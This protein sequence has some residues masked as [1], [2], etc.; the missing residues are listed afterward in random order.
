[1]KL[2]A[3]ALLFSLGFVS[4]A[5]ALPSFSNHPELI[6]EV[7]ESQHFK[8]IY[9]RTQE[10]NSYEVVA[11]EVLR[12]AEDA[13]DFVT[14]DLQVE[15]SKKTPIVLIGY[16][17]E[18]N[19]LA[20]AIN[21]SM[22]VWIPGMTQV[23]TGSMD[24]LRRTV[25]HEFTHVATY[26]K[27]EGNFPLLSKLQNLAAIP[28]WFIEGIAQ[29]E[30]E[31]L[32]N[33]RE[34]FLRVNTLEDSLLPYDRL[35]VGFLGTNIRDSRLVYEQ[36]FG[37]VRYIAGKYGREGIPQILS[38]VRRGY[39]FDDAV[40][41][42]T[43]STPQEIYRAWYKDTVIRY[44]SQAKGK[45]DLN[46][47]GSRL[48]NTFGFNYHPV[49]SPDGRR[50]AFA[51]S[52]SNDFALNDLYVMDR[53][54]GNQRAI[55]RD[56]GFTHSWSPDGQ[57]IVYSKKGV[58]W[59]WGE[60]VS[61]LYVIGADGSGR[62]QLTF[63]LF[64]WDPAF[65][66]DGERIA[67]VRTFGGRSEIYKMNA[68]GTGIERITH[69]V[70]FAENFGP[71]WSPDGKWIAFSTFQGG[72]RDIAVIDT[73]G[74]NFRKL[75]DDVADDRTPRWSPDGSFLIFIS[76]R[77]NDIPNLYAITP[78]GRRMV[79]LTDVQGGVFEPHWRPDGEEI[80]L[81]YFTSQGFNIYTIRQSAIS[82][83]GKLER[84]PESQ[85]VEGVVIP[86][87]MQ[88]PQ[89]S[90]YEYNPFLS[91]E[92]I[93]VIP[94]ASASYGK[95]F[96][97][98]TFAIAGAFMDVMEKNSLQTF[99]QYDSL[100]Q[101]P[102]YYLSYT[103]K[104]LLPTTN[105]TLLGY[106]FFQYD[107]LDNVNRGIITFSLPVNESNTVY[108]TADFERRKLLYVYDRTFAPDEGWINSAGLGWEYSAIT[109][110]VDSDINPAGGRKFGLLGAKAF[111]QLGSNYEFYQG[112]GQYREYIDL[113][114]WLRY[115]VVALRLR[116]A[117]V[118][119][120]SVPRQRL[121]YTY[122]GPTIAFAPV[123]ILDIF[124]TE[125]LIRGLDLNE[126]MLGNRFVGGSAEYRFPV[127]TDMNLRFLFIYFERL[128]SSIFFD[129]GKAWFDELEWK[130]FKVG[131]G[132]ESRLRMLFANSSVI[133]RVGVGF[134]PR[135][136]PNR[137]TGK[138]IIGIGA[139]F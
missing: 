109:S 60:V 24:W 100:V 29:Y 112:E 36:G 49:Y 8:V 85:P 38:S 56:V 57:R 105:L 32:D 101:L 3:I 55:E 4:A 89:H 129:V 113:N 139:P 106:T 63:G 125:P 135:W 65:S 52:R 99:V 138:L 42:A 17:D 11:K 96:A 33:H 15:I 87:P 34:M 5:S 75:T 1:M 114:Q 51:S 95:D 111:P 108:T 50:I 40:R 9:H 66:P 16:D 92:P 73:D 83:R 86:A 41:L 7:L 47:T 79:R 64:A 130:G 68:D 121:I 35:S 126:A 118:E 107:Y 80:A 31:S 27:L 20:N 82:I 12:I 54:G 81:C 123:P 6:W 137:M 48:T 76:D 26:W 120:P 88:I 133:L 124:S 116:G 69:S 77:D 28:A 127:F 117:L 2:L 21:N 45:D 72:K 30:A 103:N 84:A 39:S 74:G 62:R 46:D 14:E 67:F 134:Q 115:N 10:D 37:L 132:N 53:D 23:T 122:S 136:P 90:R 93:L 59:G 58:H 97:A 98:Y 119:G 104:M 43:G 70:D 78:D 91:V 61:D 13:Y 94:F 25:T 18:A 128:H 22:I 102:T 44:G 131:F 19:G 110:R 71:Q